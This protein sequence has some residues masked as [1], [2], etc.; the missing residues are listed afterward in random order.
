MAG[1]AFDQ[2]SEKHAKDIAGRVGCPTEDL[3]QL[4]R[5]MKEVDYSQIVD[6]HTE[7]IVSLPTLPYPTLY[8]PTVGSTLNSA[9]CLHIN[10]KYFCLE[11]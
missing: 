2:E 1:W 7:Y 9:V 6:T 4:V 10:N 5:C 8:L 3:D 11:K